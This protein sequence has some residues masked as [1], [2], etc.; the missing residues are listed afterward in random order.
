[1]QSVISDIYLSD[2][3]LMSHFKDEPDQVPVS[4]IGFSVNSVSGFWFHKE[5][6]TMATHSVK[7]TCHV[8]FN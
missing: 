6:V 7:L 3:D 2:H 1:M 8:F 5:S 4:E